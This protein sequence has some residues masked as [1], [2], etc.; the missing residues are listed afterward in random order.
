LSDVVTLTYVYAVTWA[1]T[2]APE[3]ADVVEHGELAAV[4]APV[5]EG[6]L[7]ARRRDLL[8]HA[9][10]VQKVFDRDTVVPLRFGTVVDDVV[11]DLLEPRHDELVALLRSLQGLAEL[12]VRVI[13]REDDVLRALLREEPRLERL[14]R[15]A[16]P[17]EL[18]EAVARALDAR[19]AAVARQVVDAVQPY[20]RDTAID[21]L[22]TTLDVL[23][24]AFLVEGG[25]QAALE[26]ELERLAR[27]HAATASFKV[28]GP[29]PPHHFVRLWEGS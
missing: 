26:A 4:T 17:V 12:T 10:V 8:R 6:D 9:E 21:E 29:L 14:R 15:S 25:R 27:E 2:P 23:R 22:R 13:F 28:T 3:G 11:A 1:S 19:R 5:Q 7:R 16:Q 18:G 20:V 24:A